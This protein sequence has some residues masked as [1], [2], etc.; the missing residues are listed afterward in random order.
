MANSDVNLKLTNR[1]VMG[2]T[3]VRLTVSGVALFRFRLWLG[4]QLVKLGAWVI[5]SQCR[6]DLDE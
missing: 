2:S 6:I 3:T 1:N 5:G 4:A